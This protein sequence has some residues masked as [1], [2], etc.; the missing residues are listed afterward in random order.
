MKVARIEYE[1]AP[2]AATVDG[3]TVR[4]L[5]AEVD[6]LRLLD[7][8]VG[9]GNAQGSSSRSRLW[10]PGGTG[11]SSPGPGDRVELYVE[12]IGTLA[13]MVTAGV[14]PHPLPPARRRDG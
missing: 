14:D 7:P 5:E 4:G 12:G 13:N 3:D 8:G 11:I 2:R 9:A 6:V 1:G 10:Q